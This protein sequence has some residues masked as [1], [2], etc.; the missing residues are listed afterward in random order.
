VVIV[1]IGRGDQL[2]AVLAA[3]G[4]LADRLKAAGIRVRVDERTQLSPGFKFNDWELRGA[5]VRLE[6]GPRDLEAGTAVMVRRLGDTGKEQLDLADAPST[7]LNVL[8]DFQAFL[9]DRATAF[10]DEH[11]TTVDDWTA[12]T[13][14][15]STG[16]AEAFHCGAPSCEDDIKSKTAATPRCVPLTAPPATGPCIHCNTP[17]AYGKRVTF[18]RAY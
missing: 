8:D 4:E 18:G 6:L 3:A 16:W 7:L 9:L 15:V 17:S 11:T 10:R 1:P 2:D 13:T 5:P 12:F 14:A